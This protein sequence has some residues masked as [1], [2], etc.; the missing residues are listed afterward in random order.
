[1]EE[2]WRPRKRSDSSEV[3]ERIFAEVV[4]GREE[5]VAMYG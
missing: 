1:M 4:E 5:L 3:L 2:C